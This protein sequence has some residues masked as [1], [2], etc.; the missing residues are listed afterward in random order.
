MR[1][2]QSWR[3]SYR[4]SNITSIGGNLKKSRKA[5]AA[6]AAAIAVVNCTSGVHA[7]TVTSTWTGTSS[8]SWNNPA[9]WNP[10][11]NFPNNGNGGIS[12]YDVTIPSLATQPALNVTATIDLVSLASSAT[13]SL[14]GSSLLSL[15]ASASTDNG[16]IIINSN[17]SS[18]TTLNFVGGTLSGTGGILLNAGGTAALV[19]GVLTLGSGT[20]ISGF[21]DV[22]AALTNNGTVDASQSG[23]SLTL[24]TSAMT[25]NNLME[26]T[27]SGN[28]VVSGIT[29]TQ[30]AAGQFSAAG[31]SIQLVG[32][33]ISGGTLNSSAGGVFQATSSS[34]DTLAGTVTNN[35]VFD[36]VGASNLNVTGNLVD[37][38]SV[39]VN[40]NQSSSSTLTFSGGT[41]SGTGVV[42]LNNGGGAATLAGT[43]IQSSGHT[44]NGFGQITANLTNNGMV[45]ATVSGGTLFVDGTAMT[46][47]ATM[48]A[49]TGPLEFSG[50]SVTNTGGSIIA[51][52]N[53]VEL[54]GA[55]ITG[56]TLSSPSGTIQA[57]GS[58]TVTLS[59]VTNNSTFDIV[60]A[61]NVNVTGNLLN[62][63]TV[64]INSNQ[65]SSSSLTFSSGT[66]SGTGM[67]TL[68]SGSTSATLAGTLTQA[69]GQTI[70]GLGQI[71]ANL[72]N[73]GLVNATVAGNTL[74]VDGTSVTNSATMQATGGVLEFSNGISVTNTGGKIVANGDPVLLS[75]ATITGG[76]LSSPSGT[77]QAVNS[78]TDIL[79]GVT[80]NSTLDIVGA[81]NVNVN[82]NLA[83]NGSITVNSNNSSVST[84]NFSSGT[85]SGTGTITL[86][87]GATAATLAGTLTQS[88]GHTING[89]GQ[90]AAN[91]TNNGLVNANITSTT[92]EVDGTS[93]TNTSTMEATAGTLLLTSGVSVNNAGGTILASGTNVVVSS[94][95]VTG[96]NLSSSGAVFLMQTATL[97]APTLTANST[98]D[99][100]GG[101]NVTLT[102]SSIT[103]NGS[104]VLNFNQSS[105]SILQVNSTDVLTGSGTLTLN[106]GGSTAVI[107]TGTGDS[108]TQDVHHTIVGFGEIVG[109]FTNNGTVDAN[110]SGQSLTLMTS[111]M[112][113]NALMEATA[114]GTL[115]I[116][117]ITLTQGTSGQL[118]AAGGTIALIG[119]ATIS[120]GTL[121]TSSGGVIQATS[122][123]T[124]TLA[125][126]TNNGTFNILGASNL[127]VTGNLSDNG[128]ITV[129]SNNNSVSTMTFSGGTLS[130]TGA[131]TLNSGSSAATLAGT[132]TQASGHTINGYGQITANLTNN[133]MV[134]ATVATSTL[135]VD[136]TSMS[137]AATMEA[138]TGILAFSGGV[139]VNNAGGLIEA[140]GNTV[141]LVGVAIS[142]GTLSSPSGVI[143]GI[144]SSVETLTNVTNTSTLNI[145]G[146][147]NLNISG[148]L[149]D[150]GSIVINSNNNSVSTMMFSGGTLSG[151]GAITLNSGSS[152]AT[153]AGTLTQSSG[154]TINGFG[155]ITAN[156][157]NNGLVNATVA[158]NTLFVDGVGMSN[159]GTMEATTGILAF[160]SG[161]AVNNAGGVISAN[162]NSV[163]LT[164]A[165][166][167]GGTLNAGTVGI[168]AV[169]SS[170]NTLAGVTITGQFGI[171]GA[172]NVNTTGTTTN[173]G[174]ITINTNSSST[175]TLSAGGPLAGTG[176]VVINSGG[177]LSFGASVGGST[178][179]GLTITGSGRLDLNNNHL[180]INYGSGPDPVSSIAALLASGYSAGAWNGNGIFSTAAQ[181]NKSYGLGYAD[182]A[183]PGNPA[184]LSS[185]QIEVKYTLLGDADLNNVVNGIDFGILAANFN[186]AVSRWDQ[187]DFNYDS[188]D[189]GIDFALL[190]A[191]F[192]KGASGAA[193]GPGAWSD[194]ALVA[195]AAA[196]RLLADVPEPGSTV[197]VGAGVVGM[198]A[199]RRRRRT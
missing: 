151:T 36:I 27:G 183:D 1:C 138:T 198:L 121:N 155:Q 18:T 14:L 79:A 184:G 67:I 73:N 19:S 59:G 176:T 126:V 29:V 174:T 192:N 71:T 166:I 40:N 130:G 72:T 90:I 91:L 47:S 180:F 116:N 51:N 170:S 167:T 145:Q 44:I 171:Q 122:S 154:H 128:L 152:A 50:V 41:L 177:Q 114:G 120:G 81:S 168:T 160:S 80:N 182:S 12:D 15:T 159:A 107:A 75:S 89:F 105:N 135:F 92:L 147:S 119:G 150:K 84:L 173:N 103:N 161:V 158:S 48:Q 5:L 143:Q 69:S 63:G 144:N 8:N 139:S 82:G 163:L 99:I 94:A 196:N 55:T 178:I 181:T 191:N 102:G 101:F 2:E 43:L 187:G 16:T 190:A 66:L 197:L 141:D 45:N 127:S 62:N 146:A 129:N 68:N 106:S 32:A 13:L 96:G 20:N 148:N 131:I 70:N 24:A 83:D 117:G 100:Q 189:N 153:L 54:V 28:L 104:I 111:A 124:D 118:S 133:G 108:L 78:S 98:M 58:S 95:T 56:G 199:R 34:S 37:N 17:Q 157:T 26:A 172:S 76:T 194:P 49:T 86:N 97:S 77:I 3:G 53:G 137:N 140:N 134:N 113:T 169:N 156:L 60:G 52:G 110:V 33:T 195:F 64:T 193:A 136:G 23:Q 87:S 65:S 4:Q 31:G 142:G 9:N 85:L 35:A 93:M 21:G 61:S 42:T 11:T 39:V 6:I 175:S 25:N 74:F 112:T 179:G 88:S 22:T 115:T 10:S 30:G 188:I 7:V 38:G 149:V 165:T 57:L 109:S 123:S 125:S 185:G 162:G 164:G 132:L 186:K 46:N